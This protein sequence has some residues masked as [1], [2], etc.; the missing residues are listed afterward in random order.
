MYVFGSN[1]VYIIRLYNVYLIDFNT[2]NF[3]GPV[4]PVH[5]YRQNT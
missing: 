2:S 3:K 5:F 4:S 1:F